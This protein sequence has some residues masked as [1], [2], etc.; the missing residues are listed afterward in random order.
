MFTKWL[1]L[2]LLEQ[3]RSVGEVAQ[4]TGVGEI[5]IHKLLH[6]GTCGRFT[7]D[8]LEQSLSCMQTSARAS[9]S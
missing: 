7:I 5:E 4:T 9:K 8:R 2:R 6:S 3:G 1:L